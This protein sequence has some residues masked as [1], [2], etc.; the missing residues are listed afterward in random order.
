MAEKQTRNVYRLCPCDPCDVER[1][2]SWLEDLAAEGLFLTQDGV[3]CGVFTFERRTPQRVLYRLDVAQKQKPRFFGGEADLTEEEKETYRSMGWE[4]LLQYGEF[5]VYRAAAPDA[6]ELNT[7]S[8]THALTI[9]FLRKKQRRAFITAAIMLLF[10]LFHTGS[11]LRYSFLNAVQVG[12]VFTLCIYGFLLYETLIPLA[13]T[14]LFRRYEKRLLAGDALNRHRSWRKNASIHYCARILPI[15]LCCGVAFGLLTSLVRLGKTF[16][17]EQFP[18]EP[19][20]AVVKD[21][22]PEGEVTGENNWLDYGEATHWE[23]AVAVNMEWNESCD[24]RS[25]DGE[26]CFCILRLSYHETA[27]EWLARGLERDYYVYDSTRY[28]RKRF[29]DLAAPEL[30]VDSVRVYNSYGSL[31]VL[32]RERNRVVHAVV[33]LDNGAQQNQWQLWAE[34]MAEKLQ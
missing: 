18:G 16:P 34:A 7:E 14:F 31:Y 3:F 10:W 20:F 23:N 8:R 12:A 29:Q 25:A 24:V 30:D 32:M 21:V 27:A 22:F 33:L 1:L 19:P 4:Y 2:Q 9:G 5:R 17:V 6:P 11:A 28:G 13:R 15:L 26:S